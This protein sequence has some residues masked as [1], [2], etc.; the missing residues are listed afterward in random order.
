MN[1]LTDKLVMISMK[2]FKR[3]FCFVR[4]TQRSINL[5]LYLIYFI[6][7]GQQIWKNFQM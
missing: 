2:I 6:V 3:T 4:A 7:N 1:H 5:T